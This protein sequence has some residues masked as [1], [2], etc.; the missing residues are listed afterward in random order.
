V[1]VQ[2]ALELRG[3]ARDEEDRL[4]VVGGGRRV[5][6]VRMWVDK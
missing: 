1:R 2:V 3:A 6:G 5:G 4:R